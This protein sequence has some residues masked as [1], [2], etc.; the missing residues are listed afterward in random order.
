MD[1]VQNVIWLIVGYLIG[2][3]PTGYLAAKHVK[4]IDIRKH[5]SGNVGATNVFRIAG[6]GWGTTV[7]IIDILK[8][9]MVTALLA[10]SSGAFPDLNPTLRQFLF[11]AAAIAGH[12]WTPWLQLKGGKGVATSAGALIG[13]FPLATVIALVIWTICFGVWRYVSLASIVA[14]GTFPVLLFIF[15]RD[16]SSF[17]LIFLISILLATL[18]VYNHRSN[19]ERL[20]RGEEPRV[21]F[22]KDKFPPSTSS[23]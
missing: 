2:S 13:I 11:G 21:H 20:K 1:F 17:P 12:T 16:I 19:I 23:K 5:G 8:G 6:K 14:A 18:L 10:S 9:W 4:G 7:L 3:I 22:G 15:Y